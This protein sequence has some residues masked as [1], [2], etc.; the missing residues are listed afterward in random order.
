MFNVCGGNS[1]WLFVLIKALC[2]LKRL[3]S[4]VNITPYMYVT[5]H[6]MLT[7]IKGQGLSNC[8]QSG[9][10]SW[11]CPAPALG[12]QLCAQLDLKPLLI[13]YTGDGFVW[14]VGGC[15]REGKWPLQPLQPWLLVGFEGWS[16]IRGGLTC[17]NRRCTEKWPH[18][19]GG[20]WTEGSLVRGTTVLT[21]VSTGVLT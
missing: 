15:W 11:S 12:Q 17:E 18:K 7:V 16:V 2:L 20:L 8:K 6:D 14:H 1:H 21:W 13:V 9:Q 4:C 10:S 19:R 5:A 3:P